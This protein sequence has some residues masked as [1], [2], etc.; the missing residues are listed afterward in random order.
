MG[1]NFGL[2]AGVGLLLM[3]Y[4]VERRVV[5]FWKLTWVAMGVILLVFLN[6]KRSL[7]VIDVSLLLCYCVA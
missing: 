3:L 6:F 4:V 7:C 2:L 1:V 5:L